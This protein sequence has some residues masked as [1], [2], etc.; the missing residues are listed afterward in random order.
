[1]HSRIIVTI[2][3][4]LLFL[5]QNTNGQTLQSTS[6]QQ[7]LNSGS[8]ELTMVYVKTPAFVYENSSGDLTG[9][10]IE[11][12]DQFM[13]YM[14]RVHDV[15]L[16]VNYVE[17]DDFNSYLELVKNG[18]GGVFGL[19]NTTITNARKEE[20]AFS[21]P[22]IT[23]IAVLVTHSD[24][25]VLQSWNE[26]E[27]TFGKAVA[28][29]PKG[30]THENRIENIKNRYLNNLDI[31]NV[32]NSW[33]ALDKNLEDIGSFSYQDIALFWDYK[34]QGKPVKRHPIGDQSSEQFGIVMPKD[35][36]WVKEFEK[37]FTLG[38]G[39]RS[40]NTYREILVRHLG[41]DVIEML[42]MAAKK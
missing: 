32:N 28:Y 29:V 39:F 35:S 9:I 34:R 33:A 7:A 17:G 2:L 30:T 24:V 4:V 16:T 10:C 36:E 20:M 22:F 6:L 19:A 40:T 8:G 21:T 3:T 38:T 12:M 14:R 37:F 26:L 23:N 27:S 15:N 41:E 13:E 31:N 42:Q 5:V 1:M 18:T 11:I 25:P